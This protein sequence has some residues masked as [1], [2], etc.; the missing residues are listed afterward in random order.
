MVS[1]KLG[2]FFKPKYRLLGTFGILAG[3]VTH[4]NHTGFTVLDAK[5]A[6]FRALLTIRS[7]H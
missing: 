6:N 2:R 5:H 7:I 1:A 4:D 3:S